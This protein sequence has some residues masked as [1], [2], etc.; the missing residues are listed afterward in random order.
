MAQLNL[1]AM[2]T[3]MARCALRGHR[4]ARQH[5]QDVGQYELRRLVGGQHHAEVEQRVCV[6]FDNSFAVPRWRSPRILF[7]PLGSNT[8]PR[9]SRMSR[10][11]SGWAKTFS[12]P[13]A[14]SLVCRSARRD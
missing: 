2:G 12:P 7:L 1:T 14:M 4:I 8:W 11:G 10:W 9:A 6:R 5:R 13:R 3:A